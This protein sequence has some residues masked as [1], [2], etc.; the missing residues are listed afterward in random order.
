M[1][2]QNNGNAASW[3]IDRHVEDGRSD[4]VAFRE[5][6]GQKREITYGALSK[7]SDLVAGALEKAGLR[8]EE[9]LACLVLDQLE[10]PEI[11][12][13][14]DFT[15]CMMRRRCSGVR[16]SMEK[17]IPLYLPYTPGRGRSAIQS[18]RGS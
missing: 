6:A 13:S 12:W 2:L 3:F 16:V 8:R 15:A 10:Y 4:K 18:A 1:T 11:F 5:A 7:R 14:L 17:R 9:R